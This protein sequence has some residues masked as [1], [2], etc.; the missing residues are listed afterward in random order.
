MEKEKDLALQLE[1]QF[2][3]EKPQMAKVHDYSRRSRSS[4]PRVKSNLLAKSDA[5]LAL[6]RASVQSSIQMMDETGGR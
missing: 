1:K 4:L 2:S 6:N 5:F 3:V